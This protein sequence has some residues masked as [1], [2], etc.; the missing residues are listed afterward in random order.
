MDNKDRFFALVCLC[1]TGLII[2]TTLISLTKI[3]H[4]EG[5]IS[6]LERKLE[7][8][9][10]LQCPSQEEV[11]V[12]K[13]QQ[14]ENMNSLPDI[15]INKD[16]ENRIKRDFKDQPLQREQRQFDFDQLINETV[17][18]L[19]KTALSCQVNTTLGTECTLKPGPK[20][21]QGEKGETGMKGLKGDTGSTGLQGPQGVRGYN[22]LT[23]SKGQKGVRGYT[24]L[25]G[26]KGQKGV[27]GYTGLT[28]SKGQK[29]DT[30]SGTTYIRWGRTD[31]PSGVVKL[32]N[33]RAA[34]SPARYRGGTSDYLCLPDNPSHWSTY[35][36][37]SVGYLEGVEYEEWRSSRRRLGENMPCAVCYVPTRS[38][39]FVQQGSYSCPS[40]WNREYHGYVMSE[41]LHFRRTSTICVDSYPQAVPGTST[42]AIHGGH[43]YFLT[44][45][46][47][48]SNSELACGPY[49]D[50]RILSCAV[51][52]K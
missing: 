4:L 19:L 39:L 25:T 30:N 27:P 42:N 12:V 7:K 18:V 11:A 20:G 33:G 5:R 46:C 36:A 38:A 50:R 37:T 24:G 2:C 44:V 6:E 23:G 35:Q 8:C 26:P 51:C 48:Y 31:C 34:G 22:G 10:S 29:G 9:S 28:G 21:D 13:E 45:R 14:N 16:L 1:L 41:Y 32:Y 17:Q 49:E 52:T 3:T 40:G 43:A 15:L 47:P